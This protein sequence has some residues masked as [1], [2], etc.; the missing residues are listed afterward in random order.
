MKKDRLLNA[1]GQ[2][3]E[4][5]I[6]EATPKINN[7]KME[8]NIMKNE[9]RIIKFLR[10]PASI[11]AAI[12]VCV[13]ISGVSVLAATG[14]LQGFFENI[15]NWDGAI[16]GTT[17]NQATDEMDLKVSNVENGLNVQLTMLCPEKAPYNEFEKIGINS[18]K[19]IDTKGN[20]IYEEQSEIVE[21]TNGMALIN[22]E[23]ADLSS[24]K[25]KIII[26]EM[27]GIKKADQDLILKGNWE[28]E[29]VI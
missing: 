10:K 3:D 24:G 13:C 9:S 5:Y 20:V 18:Y 21:I 7:F 29:F 14:K 27:V 25:Y 11:A 16:I 23:T 28:D 22:I 12:T 2:I 26:D 17:Y 4:C 19:I 8:E 6:L 15:F 1:L